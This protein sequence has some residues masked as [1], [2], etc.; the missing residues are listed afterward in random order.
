MS[1]RNIFYSSIDEGL[2]K[3]LNTRKAYL[4]DFNRT[5]AQENWLYGKTAYVKLQAVRRADN[6][7]DALITETDEIVITSAITNT[8]QTTGYFARTYN[9]ADRSMPK[10]VVT[11]LSVHNEG[12]LG[13]LNKTTVSFTVF[14]RKQ[15]DDLERHFQVP[16]KNV[17]VEYGWTV[18][19][20]DVNLQDADRSKFY[21]NCKTYIGVIYNFSQQ[22]RPDGGFDCTIQLV[23]PGSLASGINTKQTVTSGYQAKALGEV[24]INSNITDMATLVDR[25]RDKFPTDKGKD[26][27]PSSVILDKPAY[28]N[29][30]LFSKNNIDAALLK[31]SI[32]TVDAAQELKNIDLADGAIKVGRGQRDV[33]INLGG[34]V[35]Y[36]LNYSVLTDYVVANRFHF[37][38]HP[39][40]SYYDDAGKLSPDLV[41][42]DPRRCILPIPE[43]C[44]YD[45]DNGKKVLSFP[46]YAGAEPCLAHIL[47]SL[48]EIEKLLEQ[49]KDNDGYSITTFLNDIFAIINSETGGCIEPMLMEM[50][51][52]VNGSI[53]A[54]TNRI[55]YIVNGRYA[56]AVGQIDKYRFSAYGKDSELRD[57]QLSTKLPDRYATA[58]YVGASASGKTIESIVV[59]FFGDPEETNSKKPVPLPDNEI[60]FNQIYKV[61]Q[62][63]RNFKIVVDPDLKSF[64][65]TNGLPAE[66]E[67]DQKADII[68]KIGEYNAKIAKDKW[69]AT[70]DVIGKNGFS[71]NIIRI[72]KGNL[73]LLSNDAAQA[74]NRSIVL[75]I[76]A[77]IT[78]DGVNGF[79]FGNVVDINY[80]PLRYQ[81]KGIEFIVTKVEDTVQGS[82]WLTT[83]TLQCRVA[84]FSAVLPGG[85][86]NN[87][88]PEVTIR[89]Q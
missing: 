22:L 11:G 76:D 68:R 46:G 45:N 37:L 66:V 88:L 7:A 83:V 29:K 75:P 86:L 13:S 31:I 27:T 24:G 2:R 21:T 87:T 55:T 38:F 53:S 71:E 50:P 49:N 28:T 19:T 40:N 54:Q 34:I 79:R 18:R 84:Q 30:E 59:D 72:M 80:L 73:K 32:N 63:G 89:P 57:L 17:K 67:I 43:H 56:P 51:E 62:S 15:L 52:T 6:Q 25:L 77:T 5:A 82:E 10:A 16:G 1:D 42:A 39:V 65:A 58:M 61:E 23:S 9:A 35:N 14:T 4:A 48:T 69:K 47:I 64:A 26:N 78:I 44:N 33:Y 81:R 8:T 20:R 60:S 36:L 74:W 85:N 3:E 41:S 70:R 12:K